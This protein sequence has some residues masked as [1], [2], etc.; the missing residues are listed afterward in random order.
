MEAKCYDNAQEEGNAM[1]MGGMGLIIVILI[2]AL[3]MDL[4]MYYNSYRRLKAV[5]DFANEEIQQ[6]LP[7]YAYADDYVEVFHRSLDVALDGHGYNSNNVVKREIDRTT[8]FDMS[9]RIRVSMDLELEDEYKCMFASFI[10]IDKIP[11]H[12]S[13]KSIQNL[14]IDEPYSAGRPYE[15]WGD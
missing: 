15:V 13:F 5:S 7:Y 8:V 9:W 11:L 4:G 3:M 10:G 12:V 14:S 6:M 1:I 2:M